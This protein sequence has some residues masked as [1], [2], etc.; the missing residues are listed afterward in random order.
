V[1]P[2]DE[3]GHYGASFIFARDENGPYYG[4]KTIFREGIITMLEMVVFAVTLVVAQLVGGYIMMQIVVKQFMN[5]EFI[6]KYT[7]MGMEVGKEL[8][9]EMEDE[10]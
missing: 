5:K 6:K 10:L 8:V 2:S 9:E 7:K 1:V 4:E 3:W